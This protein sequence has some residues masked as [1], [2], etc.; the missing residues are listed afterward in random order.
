MASDGDGAP[1][2]SRPKLNLK[3]RDPAAAAKLEQE[4]QTQAAKK[5]P[6]G[7][8]KPREAIIASRVGKTEE[9]ILKE[10][11]KKEKLH[12]RL[13]PAQLEEKRAHEAA[14]KEVEDEIGLEDDEGKREVL[15]AE[16]Q[17]RQQ[18]LDR[19]MEGFEK[20]ALETALSGSA[21]RVSEIRRQ[22]S[23][24]PEPGMGLPLP[25]AAIPGAVPPAGRY[26]PTQQ[27]AQRGGGHGGSDFGAQGAPRTGYQPTRN[28]AGGRGG[29]LEG[30]APAGG[31]YE[32]GYQPRGGGAGG[33]Y[34]QRSKPGFGSGAGYQPAGVTRD[35]GFG[36]G[37]GSQ[38]SGRFSR[39][40]S[41]GYDSSDQGFFDAPSLS[42]SGG[43]YGGARGGRGRTGG[44]GGGYGRDYGSQG[45]FGD[46]G[47]GNGSGYY[48]S[49]GGVGIGGEIDFEAQDRF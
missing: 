41:V 7:E 2:P 11:V 10:E 47:F 6:F 29:G 9:E 12:L 23:T 35:D 38:G 44:R 39:N 5:S 14:V 8:A 46:S 48:G 17:A 27:Y 49:Q 22:Q 21:P 43:G 19:L 24:G 26:H 34:Q 45:G 25:A 33:G 20:L 16:L 30:D 4:R 42:A 3:P 18:K 31:G 40:N 1:Q 37:F 36:D 32:G 28:Y 13:N 15:S